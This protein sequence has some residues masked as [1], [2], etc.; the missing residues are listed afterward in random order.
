MAEPLGGPY[1]WGAGIHCII[2]KWQENTIEN[3]KKAQENHQ[4]GRIHCCLL[5]LPSQ[6]HDGTAALSVCPPSCRRHSADSGGQ[7]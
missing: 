4:K 6:T 7:S 5:P 2:I 3:D 1:G